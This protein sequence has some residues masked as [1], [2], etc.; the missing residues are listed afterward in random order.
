MA[1]DGYL[2]YKDKVNDIYL[3]DYIKQTRGKTARGNI[4]CIYAMTEPAHKKGTDN[5]PSMGYMKING[6]YHCMTCEKMAG[7]YD[8][9]K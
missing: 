1:N 9:I 2:E 6:K 5:K 4:N 8:F 3:K 7:I